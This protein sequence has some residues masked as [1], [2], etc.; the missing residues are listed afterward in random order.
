MLIELAPANQHL[1]ALQRTLNGPAQLQQLHRFGEIVEGPV[2]QAQCRGGRVV[3][4]REHQDC[5]VGAELECL[6]HDVDAAHPGHADVAQHEG[7]IVM[8]A[9]LPQRLLAGGGRMNQKLLFGEEPHEGVPNRL[10]VVHDEDGN[11]RGV[12]R[13][14]S[15][16][17]DSEFSQFYGLA[18]V[19]VS[20]R[21]RSQRTVAFPHLRV[22]KMT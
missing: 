15:L 20:Q 17:P 12:H 22:A 21:Y 3:D 7:D 19:K 11:R 10:L 14:P 2:L 9:E 4:C 8:S 18:T 5:E 6:G 13:L 16:R 1:T